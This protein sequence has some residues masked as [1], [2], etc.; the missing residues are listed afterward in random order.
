M[1][2]VF[3]RGEENTAAQSDDRARVLTTPAA[4]KT[5]KPEVV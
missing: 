1:D 3:R 4:E 5:S 2:R